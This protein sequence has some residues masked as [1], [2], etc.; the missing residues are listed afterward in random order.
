MLG[1]NGLFIIINQRLILCLFRKN[2]YSLMIITP[3]DIRQ[4][5]N[6]K[7][8]LTQYPNTHLKLAKLAT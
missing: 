2:V 1:F 3:V 6:E 7:S 5:S 4:C 8:A